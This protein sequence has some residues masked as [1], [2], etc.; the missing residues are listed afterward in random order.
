MESV[1]DM[2]ELAG[3]KLGVITDEDIFH[4]TTTEFFTEYYGPLILWVRKLRRMV[5]PN[6]RRWKT[7]DNGM[8]LSMKRVL[9]EAQVDSRVL[10][11]V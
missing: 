7:E 6:G 1:R 8:Y 3:M 9:R 11:N 10:S 5:L 2:E 4:K